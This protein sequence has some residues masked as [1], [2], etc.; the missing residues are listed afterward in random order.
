MRI[1]IKHGHESKL[2]ELSETLGVT[3]TS[4]LKDYIDQLHKQLC[5]TPSAKDDN[6]ERPYNTK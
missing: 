5:S 2:V 3:A 1:Q 4:I 6:N